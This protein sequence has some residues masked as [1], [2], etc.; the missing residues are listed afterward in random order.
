MKPIDI[1]TEALT[2]LNEE[3]ITLPEYNK[4]YDAHMNF[5]WAEFL[6]GLR[7]KKEIEKIVKK[8]RK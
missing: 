7:N 1:L 6:N 8:F 2:A 5:T 3:K 4:I